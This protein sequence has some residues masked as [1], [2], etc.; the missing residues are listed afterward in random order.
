MSAIN[1]KTLSIVFAAVFLAAS[2]ASASYIQMT[3]TVYASDV[4][5][6]EDF[7][8]NYT[9][10]NTGDEAAHDVQLSLGLPEGM[11]SEPVYAGVMQPNQ[12]VSGVFNVTSSGSLL[13][14]TYSVFVKTQYTDANTYPFSTISP[15]TIRYLQASPVML[16]GV[17]DAPTLS[18]DSQ[19]Q[20]RLQVS[21]LDTKPHHVHVRFHIPDEL[22]AGYY[23]TTVDVDAK[24]DAA[25]S[26]GLE[27][28]GALP[29]S[30]YVVFASM[31]YEE[32]G[33]HFGATASSIVPVVENTD[34]TLPSWAPAAALL[35][36]AAAF[37]YYQVRR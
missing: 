32:D 20:L 8:L 22:K 18:K 21:N 34:E 2:S 17:I 3:V 6:A 29:G 31:E 28:F 7:G 35:I 23:S 36:L 12:P 1:L 5:S 16:R 37:I 19:Q 4:L 27:S 26:V 25:V 30:S 11:S 10:V 33:V 14:G 15:T 13:P 9:V 24:Q